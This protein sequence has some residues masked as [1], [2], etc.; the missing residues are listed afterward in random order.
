MIDF[1][2]FLGKASIGS[3]I[4]YMFYQ[5]F[6]IKETHFILNRMFLLGSLISPLIIPW[7]RNPFLKDATETPFVQILD[8]IQIS[9]SSNIVESQ[10]SIW[11]FL[12]IIY[13]IGV[14]V[15]M[16]KLTINFI[17]LLKI[18]QKT[19]TRIVNGV[20]LQVSKE[21]IS[22]FSFWKTIFLN[23]EVLSDHEIDIII[24]HETIHIQQFHTIDILL[25]EFLRIIFWFN[26][27]LILYQ[28][29]L[30]E[31][32][33]Y[34]ADQYVKSSQKDIESY[35]YLLS[36]ST[37]YPVEMSNNFNKPLILKRM[38]MMTKK[39]SKWHSTL[40]VI[41][42]IPLFL[43]LILVFSIREMSAKTIPE[44][45][46]SEF[47]SEVIVPTETES[48]IIVN[49]NT[50][51]TSVKSNS[52]IV[53]LETPQDTLPPKKSFYT[54]NEV[55]KQASFPGGMD[56]LMEYLKNNI[57]YPAECREKGIQGIVLV[58][59]EITRKGKIVNAKVLFPVDPD[60]DAE[61][62]R[63]ISKMPKWE[64]AEIKGKKVN[65]MYQIPINFKLQ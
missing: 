10:F 44:L 56:K 14:L 24:K 6:L 29:S 17:H 8:T 39:P 2:L 48:G 33:E 3:A 13:F 53:S 31:L 51:K 12:L 55:E 7:I 62:I 46:K 20:P 37:G 42:A 36:K 63:V 49:P 45:L 41:L 11:Y 26:P 18:T 34:T 38:K 65:S 57:Q 32:H 15:F 43:G 30:K 21:N 35:I 59:F 25:I 22:P 40:K 16:I 64:P 4:L 9:E 54:P 5:L 60:L 58:Q 52:I 61:S 23:T 19:E 1:I 47:S 50:P 27:F 28:N